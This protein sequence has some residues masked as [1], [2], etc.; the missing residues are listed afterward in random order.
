MNL[1]S[2][3]VP[4]TEGV[5]IRLHV[6]PK[7]RREQIVGLHDGR[8]KVSVTAAPD[9]GK[10][11][12]AVIRLLADTFAVPRSEIQL[13]RG[14]TSRQKDFLIVGCAVHKVTLQ[15]HAYLIQSPE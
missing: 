7:A 5:V 14:D 10:A 11:N 12:A 2:V 4:S 15:L 3:L 8:L 9:R 13:L 1:N 6:Q